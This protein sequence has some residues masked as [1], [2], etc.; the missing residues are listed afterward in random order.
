MWTKPGVSKESA[1]FY[2]P[3]LACFSF[4]DYLKLFGK[5]CLL[6]CRKRFP[7][8]EISS[9]FGFLDIKILAVLVAYIDTQANML[10]ASY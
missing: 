1:I 2:L 9:S 7:Q 4:C 6:S 5:K 8:K 10:D 3:P